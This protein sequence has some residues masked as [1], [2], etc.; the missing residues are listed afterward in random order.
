VTENCSRIDD[1][2]TIGYSKKNERHTKKDERRVIIYNQRKEINRIPLDRILF[3][4]FWQWAWG[5]LGSAKISGS[6]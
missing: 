5:G 3:V 6:A 2:I 1:R 4:L